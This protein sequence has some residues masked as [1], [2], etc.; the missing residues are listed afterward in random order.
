MKIL[1]AGFRTIQDANRSTN[2]DRMESSSI[3]KICTGLGLRAAKVFIG[4]A[5][6]K[7]QESQSGCEKSCA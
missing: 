3:W 2:K 4:S 7:Q 6:H 5:R 1:T